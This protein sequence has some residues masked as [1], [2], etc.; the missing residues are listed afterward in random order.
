MAGVSTTELRTVPEDK[1]LHFPPS[2]ARWVG[3]MHQL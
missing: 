1:R 3:E 2:G